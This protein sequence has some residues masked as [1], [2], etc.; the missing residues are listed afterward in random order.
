[1][2]RVLYP[3]LPM[4]GM[5]I[6]ER[7]KKCSRYSFYLEHTNRRC[8]L[9]EN[10]PPTQ[11]TLWPLYLLRQDVTQQGTGNINTFINIT[12]IN[13]NGLEYF[14][15]INKAFLQVILDTHEIKG[16]CNT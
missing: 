8:I 4:L 15:A 10:A 6:I 11:N 5:M 2:Y 3:N 16:Q 1:M 13:Y 12:T 9:Y 14:T 7:R